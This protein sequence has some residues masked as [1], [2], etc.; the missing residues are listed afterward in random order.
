M[1]IGLVDA[2]YLTRKKHRFPNLALMKLSGH[3]KRLGHS[4]ELVLNTNLLSGSFYDKI[5][6]S[7][8]FTDTDFQ[9]PEGIDF[10]KGGTGFSLQ[11]SLSLP[12]MIEH[13]YP[14]YELYSKAS[15]SGEMYDNYSIGFT[16]RG[17]IRGCDFCV[18]K[19]SKRAVLHSPVSEFLDKNRKYICLLDD[20][21]LACKDWE[22]VINS[23][24][25][26]GKPFQFKQGLDIRL[27]TPRKSKLFSES[28]LRSYPY[29]AFDL[30]KERNSVERGLSKW[31][32][33]NQKKCKAYL[34]CAFESLDDDDIENIF[35]RVEI[36]ASYKVL[37]YLMRF[38]DYKKSEN[39]GMYVNLAAYL[40]QAS[41]FEK[42][43]FREFCE[44]DNARKGGNSATMRYLNDFECRNPHI[45]KKFFDRCIWKE[46]NSS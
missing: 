45:A 43:S 1:N 20:N 13:H 46:Q 23:L 41:L 4:V 26:T 14:D 11:N 19:N 35:V 31:R 36:L 7:Q 9:I 5:F 33:Y 44:K 18:N 37:P 6:V 15:I 38:E 17:C 10:E 39:Y 16:T 29:F 25:D 40:N 42:M 27:M 8:V 34:L 21:I 12:P 24:R 2:D 32:E 28:K 30:M 22:Q 3:F